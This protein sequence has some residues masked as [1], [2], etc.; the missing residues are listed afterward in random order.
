MYF[1]R[2][3][4]CMTNGITT[5][6]GQFSCWYC[7]QANQKEDFSDL[8]AAQANKQKRKAAAKE[9]EQS[10]KYKDFKF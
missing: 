10:K 1:S 6:K 9:K 2:R 3:H 5:T 8:V 7:V 4:I